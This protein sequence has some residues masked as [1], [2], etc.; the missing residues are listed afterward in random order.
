MAIEN[1]GVV[2]LPRRR[3][4]L[5]RYGAGRGDDEQLTELDIELRIIDQARKAL[6]ERKRGVLIEYRQILRR[7]GRSPIIL[8]VVLCAA[9]GPHKA[10]RHQLFVPIVYCADAAAKV[11]R[12][13][14]RVTIP[15]D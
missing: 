12:R 11:R 10:C 8:L 3:R 7:L 1:H 2:R 6:D 5:D 13:K 15:V 9:P 14:K 4:A